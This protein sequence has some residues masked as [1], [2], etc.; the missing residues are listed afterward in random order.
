LA[1]NRH[2]RPH[3]NPGVFLWESYK[4]DFWWYEMVWIARR[5]AIAAIVALVPED[6]GLKAFFIVLTL[7]SFAGVQFIHQSFRKPWENRFDF[8]ATGCLLATYVVTQWAQEQHV[9]QALP[10]SFYTAFALNGIFALALFGLTAYPFLRFV[11]CK[12]QKRRNL[13]T[14]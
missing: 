12:C 14:L 1:K 5:L 2:T 11:A 9:G 3:D 13:A 6:G 8:F 4:K 7:V 10:I